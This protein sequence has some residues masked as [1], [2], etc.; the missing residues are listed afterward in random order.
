MFS[1]MGEVGDGLDDVAALRDEKARQRVTSFG[2]PPA[3]Y[4]PGQ[5]RQ[6]CGIWRSSA[7]VDVCAGREK[8]PRERA[9]SPRATAYALT[10]T[11]RKRKIVLPRPRPSAREPWFLWVLLFGRPLDIDGPV[12]CV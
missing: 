10:G 11:P 8:K 5:R 4:R 1:L 6:T 9:P 2:P 3:I 7:G 12:L